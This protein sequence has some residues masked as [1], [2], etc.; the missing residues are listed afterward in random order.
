MVEY[1][2]EE[3]NN[4]KLRY[5][6]PFIVLLPCLI[7]CLIDIKYNVPLMES[8]IRLLITIAV[9]F[10]LGTLAQNVIRKYMIEAVRQMEEQKLKE[11]EEEEENEND[12][13]DEEEEENEE[14][15]EE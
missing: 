12:E 13:D 15:V 5:L 4:G 14:S 10:V 3:I 8:M 6:R 1:N 9:F 7:V 2:H 11:Q